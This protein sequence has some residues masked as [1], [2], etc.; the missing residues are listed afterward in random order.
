M[1][2]RGLLKQTICFVAASHFAVAASYA[3][4]TDDRYEFNIESDVLGAA[5]DLVH[6]QTG[7]QLIY[8]FDQAQS[9]RVNTVEGRFTV[10]EAL[11]IMLQGTDFSGGLTERGVIVISRDQGAHAHIREETVK[12][13]SNKNWLLGGASA[14]FTAFLP[15]AQAIAQENDEASNGSRLD[16]IVV[17][18]RRVEESLIDS[19][20]AVSVTTGSELEK[21]DVSQ[22]TGITETAP[23]VNFSFAG[24]SSGS[25]SAAVVFIRGV[26]QNDF[27]VVSDPGVGIYVDGIFLGRSVGSVID[28]FDLEQVEVLRGPQGTVFG[29]NSVGGAINITTADVEDEFGGSARIVAGNDARFEQ[30]LTLNVPV[31]DTFGI[32]GSFFNRDRNGTV[33]RTD[34]VV[35]GDDNIFGGRLKAQW[36]PTDRFRS[37]LSFD[38]SR[39]NEESA[40]EVLLDSIEDSLFVGFFNNDTFG[41]GS[42]DAAGCLGGG[43]LTNTACANDQFVLGPFNSAET[44]PSNN[45][46]TVWGISLINEFDISENLTVKS[47]SGYRDVDAEFARA[48]DGTPFDIFATETTFDQD[49]FSQELQL[50]GSNFDNRL[51]W[52]AGAFY[53][54]E[55]AVSFDTVTFLPP[56]NPLFIGAETDNNNWAVFGEATLD[57]TDRLRVLGGV[58][59][60]D[61]SKNTDLTSISL[62][63]PVDNLSGPAAGEIDQSFTEVTWRGSVIYGLTENSNIYFTAS[64]GFKSGGVFQRVVAAVDNIADLTF[65]P[66]FVNLYELGFKTEIE[67][68][69][70]RLNIAGFISDYTDIQLDGAPPGSFATIQFNSGDASINGVEVEFD[71]SPIDNLLL[72]GAFGYIDAQYENLLPGSLVT[73]DDQ[74]VRTPEVTWSL[75]GS[76]EFDLGNRGTLI[77]GFNWVYNSSTAFEAT[78]TDLTTQ[79]SFN[80]LD[81]SLRY[82]FDQQP[83]NLTFG[84][85]NVTDA[86]YLVAADF[87]GTIGYE[88]GV[89]ARERNFF[90]A[91]GYEF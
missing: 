41:N 71:W 30:F 4:N 10:E 65:E 5:M 22:I 42:T 76:Y 13:R 85:N 58:R 19:P 3:Q 49:Q 33:E 50:I 8:P 51:N 35:L 79:D 46:S 69:G 91:V 52:V 26:G 55:D 66:E 48:S 14:L 15:N 29:R 86:E 28:I 38:I 36:T 11:E 21:G 17:T 53:F 34:G 77:P 82:E 56:T 70:L 74:L 54:Q 64:R 9:I 23:N 83:L 2:H 88:L 7:V 24:T 78:N 44:G 43:A 39:E 81:L 73:E 80:A 31:T 61:E 87:N 47:I 18:A 6:E 60:T 40:A 20:V 16:Q 57:V 72:S 27:T 68:L 67:Q 12:N 32:R 89:F 90:V 62:T 84:L 25:D 1:K 59:Y 63:A 75:N 45:D 37:T